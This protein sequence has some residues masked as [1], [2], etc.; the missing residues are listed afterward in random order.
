MN[1][2][3][4]IISFFVLI[5]GFGLLNLHYNNKFT[6]LEWDAIPMHIYTGNN[7]AAKGLTINEGI[8][9]LGEVTKKLPYKLDQNSKNKLIEKITWEFRRDNPDKVKKLN[10]MRAAAWWGT[11]KDVEVYDEI[12]AGPAIDDKMLIPSRWILIAGVPLSFI[13]MML[14]ALSQINKIKYDLKNNALMSCLFYGSISMLIVIVIVFSLYVEVLSGVVM[15]AAMS[16]MCICLFTLAIRFAKDVDNALLTRWLMVVGLIL[17]AS[18]CILFVVVKQRYRMH[19]IPFY[20]LAIGCVFGDVF[21]LMLD[22]IKSLKRTTAEAMLSK[23]DLKKTKVHKK[24]N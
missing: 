9:Y 4:A 16:A 20:S 10:M 1:Y 24:G 11:E 23:Y 15:Y 8:N 22:K 19:M 5:I 12:M 3:A 13:F 6:F 18:V 7:P 17:D 2:R 21:Y 14:T